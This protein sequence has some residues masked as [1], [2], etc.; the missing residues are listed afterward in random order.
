MS[1]IDYQICLAQATAGAETWT[2]IKD[3]G[4]SGLCRE[5]VSCGMDTVTFRV[6]SATALTDAQCFAYHAKVRLR[7]VVDGTPSYWFVGRVATVPRHATG[8]AENYTMRIEGPWSWFEACTFRQAWSA[9]GGGVT[10]PRVILFCDADGARMTTGAQIIQAAEFARAAGAPIAA[11]TSATI[12]TGFTPPFD[13][14]MNIKVADVITKALAFHPHAV[15]WFDYTQRDA[16]LHV[17]SRLD[18][19]TVSKSIAGRKGIEIS[20][21]T[22]LQVP[23]IAICYEQSGSVDGEPVVNTTLDY[24]PVISNETTE[25]RDARLAQADV[26]WACYSLQGA[27]VSTAS[28][29]ITAAAFPASLNDWSWWKANCPQLS[30]YADADVSLANGRRLGDSSLSN[31]LTQGEKQPW[32]STLS[33]ENERIRVDLSYIK[34]AVIDGTSTIIDRGTKS[35]TLQVR[36]TGASVG[37]TLYRAPVSVDEGEPVPTGIAAELYAEWSQLH[38]QGSVVFCDDDPPGT[39]VPGKALNLTG[40]RSEWTSMAAMIIRSSED[41]DNGETSVEFGVPSW[42]DIDSRVAFARS[43]RTRRQAES[44]VWRTG[45]TGDG[46]TGAL[47]GALQRDGNVDAAYVRQLFAA[48]STPRHMIV[49]DPEAVSKST[50]ASTASVLAPRELY[51][52]YVDTGDG[53]KVKAKLAQVLASPLYGSA[54]ELSATQLSSTTPAAVAASGAVGTG[55]TA[56]RADHVH[57]GLQLGTSTPA[58][59]AASGSAGSATTAAK[60]DHVHAGLQLTGSTPAAID[61]TAAVGSATSAA[62]ADHKHAFSIAI[63]DPGPGTG[64]PTQDGGTDVMPAPAGSLGSSA[65]Y[66]RRDHVHPINVDDAVL[67]ADPSSSASAGT[68]NRYA[69]RDHVHKD[70]SSAILAS[71]APASVGTSNSVGDSTKAARANHV[72]AGLQLTSSAPAAV[73]ATAA[74]GEATSA[75]RADH[76]HVG[77]QLTASAPPPVDGSAA[78]AGSSTAAARA[79]H[80]HGLGVTIPGPGSDTGAPARD[81]GNAGSPAPA[82]SLGTSANFSRRDHVHPGNFDDSVL[83]A[84]PAASAAAGTSD[85][86][87]RANH[88]HKD[89]SSALLTSTAPSAVGTSAAVGDAT[90]AA[91]ANHV[92]ALGSPADPGTVSEL[93][94]ASEGSSDSADTGTWTSGTSGIKLW[95][96]SR[97]RL[98]NVSGSSNF[99]VFLRPVTITAD[100]RIYACGAETQVLVSPTTTS[101]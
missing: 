52:P 39:L 88:V 4:G 29:L 46:V 65:Y 2:S 81:C 51:I 48:T 79:D 78:S 41:V 74:V 95:V 27:S 43:T 92:H 59:V 3:L 68:S 84:D 87:A 37:Q 26:L 50:E 44:R 15:T 67:P 58:A 94:A 30:E 31:L 85:R 80:V 10:K 49:L 99:Y 28:Q 32:M 75:A 13:E 33:V 23:A 42:T 77:L 60:S 64:A 96:V 69:R 63:P 83:P 11:V 55:T 7:K 20:Q 40:G 61:G 6:N 93:G 18:L 45:I 36:V 19:S 100:G 62:K 76:V 72:H 98:D 35:L 25:D 24:A 86:Y 8:S 12:A 53:N 22:D 1:T 14:Q 47:S 91:R 38:F 57:A 16:V 101:A 90:T 70:M 21:R 82:G 34:R 89:L 56:A 97:T 54:V 71:E 17:A 66:S 5:L 73:G 9:A